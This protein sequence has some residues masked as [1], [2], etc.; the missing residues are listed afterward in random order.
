MWT[1]LAGSQPP[2]NMKSVNCL[3]ISLDE[4]CVAAVDFLFL[5]S[6]FFIIGYFHGKQNLTVIQWSRTCVA[7]LIVGSEQI[8]VVPFLQNSVR[9]HY[10]NPENISVIQ[11]NNNLTRPQ[12]YSHKDHNTI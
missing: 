5:N 7:L 2:Q 8:W 9:K 4:L 10:P 11:E 6:T 12:C 1:T 3:Y